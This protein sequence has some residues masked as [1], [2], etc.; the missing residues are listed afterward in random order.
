MISD[1]RVRI[2]NVISFFYFLAILQ[3]F[4][5][6]PMA[7]RFP[8]RSLQGRKTIIAFT[9]SEVCILN[10]SLLSALHFYL[11]CYGQSGDGQSRG[12]S[13]RTHRRRDSTKWDLRSTYE[14]WKAAGFS[15]ACWETYRRRN[16]LFVILIAH[17]LHS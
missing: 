12:C 14:R 17:P 3:H 11:Q 10:N 2:I 13:T 15:S 16:F 6:L 8:Y 4:T 5:F 7:P 1:I 9:H